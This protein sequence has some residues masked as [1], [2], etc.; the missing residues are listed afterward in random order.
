L[1]LCHRTLVAELRLYVH[2]LATYRRAQRV[3]VAPEPTMLHVSTLFCCSNKTSARDKVTWLSRFFVCAT[4]QSLWWL[5]QL[6]IIRD[7]SDSNGGGYEDGSLL[8]HGAV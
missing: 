1:L 6:E 7:I 2:I 3:Q 4:A 5:S 8:G